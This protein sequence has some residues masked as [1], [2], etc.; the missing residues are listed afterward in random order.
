MARRIQSC[1]CGEVDTTKALRPAKSGSRFHQPIA[2]AVSLITRIDNKPP[3][4]C[5]L[6]PGLAAINKNPPDHFAVQPGKPR[7]VM[8]R[9]KTAQEFGHLGG[10]FRLKIEVESPVGIIIRGLKFRYS[11]QRSR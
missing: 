3:E 7:A 2:Q 6:I 9:N 4:T 1:E 10:C 8:F 11:A 5:P